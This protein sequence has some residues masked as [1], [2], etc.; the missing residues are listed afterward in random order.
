VSAHSAALG[1]LVPGVKDVAAS[2]QRDFETA[3]REH[4]RARPLPDPVLASLFHAL[5]VQ[6]ARVYEEAERVFP[7]SVLD[8]LVAGLGMPPRLAQPAQTVVRFEGIRLRDTVTPDTQLYGYSRTGEPVYFAPD[9]AI[10][11]APTTLV[12]AAIHDGG[13]LRAVS[14]A[15]VPGGLDVPPG[16]VPL[17]LAAAPTLYLAFDT[18]ETHLGGLGLF[19]DASAAVT[20]ALARSP[21]QLLDADGH[22]RE[23]GILR[24][25]AGR[26]GVRR[27]A[28]FRDAVPAPGAGSECAA[29]LPLVEGPDGPRVWVFPPVP[30]ERRTRSL[31]PPAL[32]A[33]APLLLPEDA[34]DALERP[35]AWLQVP[36]PAELRG[37]AD[38]VHRVETNCVSVSNVEVLSEDVPFDRMGTV[39]SICLEGKYQQHVMGV[40]SVAGERDRYAE[41][42]SVHAAPGEGR[43]RYRDGRIE[44]CPARSPDGRC[45]AHAVVRL[46]LCDGERGNGVEVGK[47][48]RIE[49]DANLQNENPSVTNL[50]VS[51][52]GTAPPA[53]VGLSASR[54]GADPP[55][56][57]KAYLRF[58]ELLRTRERVVTAADVEVVARAFEPRIGAVRVEA[59]AEPGPAGV[60]RVQRVTVRVRPGDFADHEAELPRLGELLKEH[61]QARVALGQEVRVTV[62]AV[63]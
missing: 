13:T 35:L 43:W 49:A 11:L 41:E 62:E 8:G 44:L 15:R 31:P 22:V 48:C 33:A 7:V 39:V 32:R 55:D 1:T 2:L 61:L 3:M 60:T 59:R 28:W 20:A 30:P 24:A 47:V 17:S 54:G 4:L 53:A 37:V 25:H 10:E 52:G 58:A 51:R 56:F 63:R 16:S 40:L 46:L 42:A 26:A 29:A 23:E 6:V 19:V 5:A 18:D 9:E 57:A 50:T 27:L 14:G 38:A 12:F 45:D 36:L 34:G 21:W